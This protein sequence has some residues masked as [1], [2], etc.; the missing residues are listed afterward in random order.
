M[1]ILFFFLRSLADPC[2]VLVIVISVVCLV[3][4]YFVGSCSGASSSS[5]FAA[6]AASASSPAL[7]SAAAL[8]RRTDIPDNV[9]LIS[10]CRAN[11]PRRRAVSSFQFFLSEKIVKNATCVVKQQSA[12]PDVNTDRS[13]LVFISSTETALDTTMARKGT[14]SSSSVMALSHARLFLGKPLKRPSGVPRKSKGKCVKTTQY[15]YVQVEWNLDGGGQDVSA[16]LPFHAM[17]L[18]VSTFVALITVKA[19]CSQRNFATIV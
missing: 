12:R 13:E 8:A 18:S 1:R 16:Y 3:V 14:S 10:D 15:C 7:S 5:V 2:I 4:I 9:K 17:R 11:V 6:A 19:V